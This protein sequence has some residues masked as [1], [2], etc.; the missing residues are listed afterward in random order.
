MVLLLNWLLTNLMLFCVLLLIAS[1][2]Y[3]FPV[4]VSS[5]G[6]VLIILDMIWATLSAHLTSII[7]AFALHSDINVDKL[8]RKEI[9]GVRIWSIYKK[10]FGYIM[11][12][13]GP[14][15]LSDPQ[16]FRDYQAGLTSQMEYQGSLAYATWWHTMELVFQ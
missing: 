10:D 1:T 5:S 7:L 2:A 6:T 8:D 16:V 12:L 13:A 9:E 11:N 4:L 15:F 14:K 3:F